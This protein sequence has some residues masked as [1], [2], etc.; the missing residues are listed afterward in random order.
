M[1]APAAPK[2]RRR[3]T[4]TESLLQIVLVLEACVM[5]FVTLTAFG[6]GVLPPLQ[7]FLGGGGLLVLLAVTAGLTRHRWGVWLGWALQAALV[8]TGLLMPAMFFVAALFLAFWIFCF[9]K[10]R[11][12]DARNAALAAGT[13]SGTDPTDPDPTDPDTTPQKETE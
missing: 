1:T 11:Q 13:A 3:R 2:P 8:A 4:A 10:G 7:V 9:V 5:F 6:L 12:L